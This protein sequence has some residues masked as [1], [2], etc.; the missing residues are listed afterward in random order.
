MRTNNAKNLCMT[1]QDS[2]LPTFSSFPMASSAF[3]PDGAVYLDVPFR[4][5]DEAKLAG[6]FWVP[7]VKKWA[8][9]V[10]DAEVLRPFW[11]RMHAAAI[12]AAV[13]ERRKAAAARQADA[14]ERCGGDGEGTTGYCRIG[15]CPKG[16]ELKRCSD[17]LTPLS[18]RIL[19]CH[20]GRC[21]SCA[22]VEFSSK[23]PS[24]YCRK[25]PRGYCRK[26]PSGY[27]EHCK[28]KLVPIGSGRRNGA[29]HDDWDDRRFHKQCYKAR[30]FDL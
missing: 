7:G 28:R 3:M 24:G 12:D 30:L 2:Q 15:A 27:C 29:G 19:N 20:G 18:Q 5:K 21:M 16:C 14:I 4:C 1:S 17:C 22:I 23:I 8:I 11:P 9:A 25:V 6:A 13:E 10:Y 26:V